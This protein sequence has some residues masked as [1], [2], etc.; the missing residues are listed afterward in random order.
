ML[1][2]KEL[3]LSAVSTMVCSMSLSLLFLIA[4]N[5]TCALGHSPN[6]NCTECVFND[7][8]DISNPCLNGGGCISFSGVNNYTCNCTGTGYH[9]INCSGTNN[10][11]IIINNY[12]N[13]LDIMHLTS[14]IQGMPLPSSVTSTRPTSSSVVSTTTIRITTSFPTRT[15]SFSPSP[16]PSLCRA[17]NCG[18][19][20]SD[21]VCCV[22]CNDGYKI[23]QD[24]CSC[25]KPN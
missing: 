21:S 14:S 12:Y 10:N 5:L 2:V 25:G 8:C 22:Q 18:E 1:L 19:C 6:S 16:S 3:V 11:A 23:D 20:E 17:D 13:S 15:P 9:G 4:C 7:I 24:G